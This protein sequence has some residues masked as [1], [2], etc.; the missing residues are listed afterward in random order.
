MRTYVLLVILIFS[1]IPSLTFAQA[2]K[3]VT[4]E[5]TCIS[6]DEKRLAEL[7]NEYRA[8]RKLPPIPL[9]V[10]LSHVA[11]LHVMDLEENF[12]IGGKCNLHSWSQ[13]SRWSSCC[14]T[15]DHKKSPC[16]WD[17][18]REL[19]SYKG[20]GYEIAYF[21]TYDYADSEA[22]MK[23]AVDGWK[24][25]KGHREIVINQ[26]K[27]HDAEWKAMGVGVYGDYAVVWFGEVKD[28][29]GVPA[30]CRY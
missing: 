24:S 12:R 1:G 11:R 9:S 2:T 4:R 5:N 15:P 23:D 14:Y 22:F 28:S 30:V 8:S 6:Q 7:I 25:S 29:E 16:M 20:D 18:P 19:T 10:S 17:K 13:D 26:G 21:S 27:W 3:T